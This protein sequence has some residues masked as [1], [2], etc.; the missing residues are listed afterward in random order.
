MLKHNGPIQKI[1][2]ANGKSLSANVDAN[3]FVVATNSISITL[4]SKTRKQSN[5]FSNFSR[6]LLALEVE[7]LNVSIDENHFDL[8]ITRAISSCTT[9]LT[10]TSHQ[11]LLNV[12][13][14]FS[15]YIINSINTSPDA[16]KLMKME[17]TSRLQSVTNILIGAKDIGL[18]GCNN[19][20]VGATKSFA[21]CLVNNTVNQLIINTKAFELYEKNANMNARDLIRYRITKPITKQM[22]SSAEVR[23]IP[24][25]MCTFIDQ[26][27]TAFVTTKIATFLSSWDN[28]FIALLEQLVTSS[29][30]K[31]A[32]KNIP[33]VDADEFES[34]LLTTDPSGNTR[35]GTMIGTV[36]DL[37]LPEN[38]LKTIVLDKKEDN[39]GKE[40]GDS[41]Q[42]VDSNIQS[43]I[44][45]VTLTLNGMISACNGGLAVTFISLIALYIQ[46]G[47][48]CYN[49]H[50]LGKYQHSSIIK[51]FSPEKGYNL[52]LC[53]KED[54]VDKKDASTEKYTAES[55]SIA[56]MLSIMAREPTRAE[57]LMLSELSISDG[58][59]IEKYVSKW[60]NEQGKN[61]KKEELTTDE[62]KLFFNYLNKCYGNKE[63]TEDKL[64]SAIAYVLR[65]ADVDN[66]GTIEVSELA[67]AAI[68]YKHW[69][70]K[71]R[72]QVHIAE[73]IQYKTVLYS[74]AFLAMFVY[75][76][77]FSYLIYFGIFFII[78]VL[79][80]QHL[81]WV[82]LGKYA[83]IW[84]P[85]L[86]ILTITVVIRTF[87]KRNLEMAGGQY[88]GVP[89]N[90]A[91]FQ[92]PNLYQA[93]L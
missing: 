3:T 73:A 33:G 28:I 93:D 62:L 70:K 52:S 49:I 47:L 68:A 38:N 10:E 82:A 1:I 64:K 65:T 27:F 19:N 29:Y 12:S 85:V 75:M 71:K 76:Q 78:L 5:L 57:T 40:N 56:D 11:V 83:S 35:L 23:D 89:V 8:T 79:P 32:I 13:S 14:A 16:N 88:R 55:F 36:K 34:V 63:M 25:K 17:A 67:G 84:L 91:L 86:V 30:F 50:T 22:Y 44:D 59:R 21:T 7:R 87:M 18:S 81:F 46:L 43:L 53:L 9:K 45:I 15:N 72:L 80:F 39:G 20:F 42:D 61:D 4:N 37:I 2:E 66:S 6:N 69:M 24:A 90:S 31:A 77:I 26:K 60:L 58:H 48:F 54:A 51:L 74:P 92:P 41:F